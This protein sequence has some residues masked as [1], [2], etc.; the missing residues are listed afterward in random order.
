MTNYFT[1]ILGRNNHFNRVQWVNH[2]LKK[3]EPGK[4][5]LDVGA[6]ELK[7][8]PSCSHLKYTSQDFCQYDGGG[9]G[10]ALQTGKWDTSKIDIV[11]DITLIPMPDESYDVIL[12]SEVLEH[13]PHPD[14]AIK[15]MARLLKPG[16]KLIVTAPFISFTHFSPFHFSTG[17]NVYWYDYFFKLNNLA[18]NE[19]KK[20]GNFFSLLAQ[21]NFRVYSLSK[22]YSSPILG[23]IYLLLFLPL[24][25]LLLLISFFDSNRSNELACFGVFIV[26]KKFE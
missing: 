5:I 23:L 22:K 24:Y 7:F 19:I 15:E 21:E 14:I 12:C 1:K 11:S 26:A 3:I 8:K 6:G 17:F 20:N 16:G 4:K 25:L 13:V 9:D 10:T 18:I 2:Q